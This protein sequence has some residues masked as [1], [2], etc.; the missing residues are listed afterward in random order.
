M[1]KTKTRTFRCIECGV[2]TVRPIARVGRR[3]RYKMME[4]VLPAG[5]KVPTCDKCGVEYLSESSAAAEDAALE[6]L[7]RRELRRRAKEAIERLMPY[8]DERD[9]EQLMGLSRGYLSRLRTGQRDPS[10]D[11]VALMT[12]LA[13]N[14]R[15]RVVELRR[16]W[17][18]TI[19]G[20]PDA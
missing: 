14:P 5:V 12:L 9:L 17:E 1:S 8:V 20:K 11:L 16:S 4:L 13:R 6:P 15:Q 19:G 18:A 10:A 2:G 7:Y 3:Q